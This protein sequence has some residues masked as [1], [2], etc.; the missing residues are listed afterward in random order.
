MVD[1]VGP[2]L[3]PSDL[4]HKQILERGKAPLLPQV[5]YPA[6]ILC[7]VLRGLLLT[8]RQKLRGVG[9]MDHQITHAEIGI[10]E[11]NEIA[12]GSPVIEVLLL[13]RRDVDFLPTLPSDRLLLLSAV[14]IDFR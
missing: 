11:L 14:R 5:C 3:L 8:L 13:R 7:D 9:Q 10:G 4:C 6:Q 12:L 1:A 2:I